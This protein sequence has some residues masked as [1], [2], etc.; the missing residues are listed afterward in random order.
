LYVDNLAEAIGMHKDGDEE[1]IRMKNILNGER[2]RESILRS[3]HIPLTSLKNRARYFRVL[4]TNH[5]HFG[6]GQIIYNSS[7]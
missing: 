5:L 4:H 7:F 2:D 1:R 3:I 6:T